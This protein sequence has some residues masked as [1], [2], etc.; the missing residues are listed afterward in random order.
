MVEIITCDV[1]ITKEE[2]DSQL[3]LLTCILKLLSFVL[4]EDYRHS[5]SGYTGLIKILE[6]WAFDWYSGHSV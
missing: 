6:T 3:F 5:F 1:A 4:T 2:Q